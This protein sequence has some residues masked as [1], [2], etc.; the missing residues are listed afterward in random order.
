MR[1]QEISVLFVAEFEVAVEGALER[2]A[3]STRQIDIRR[4]DDDG[5]V[6]TTTASSRSSMAMMRSS[7]CSAFSASSWWRTRFRISAL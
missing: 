7:G 6:V 3:D 4:R 5:V 2:L 1:A